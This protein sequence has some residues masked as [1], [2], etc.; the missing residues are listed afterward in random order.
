MN[1][2]IIKTEDGSPTL[3]ANEFGEHYHSIHGARTES[4][5]IFINAGFN[6]CLKPRLSVLEFGFGSGLNALLT[7]F[8]ARRSDR[9]LR[10][11]AIEKYPLLEEETDALSDFFY[12]KHEV[13]IFRK[14]HQAPWNKN[15]EIENGFTLF[16]EKADFLQSNPHGFF[17]VIYFDAFSPDVQPELWKLEM[18]KKI[19]LLCSKG[20]IL[21][22][23]SS[24]GEVRRNLKNVGFSV[25]KLPGPPGKREF[26]RAINNFS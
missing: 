16:K 7:Y 19:Q 25:E 4:E 23:Y 6:A 24:K 13:D 15:T 8:A 17:D 20:A 2:E 10:Y 5:H 14:M 11:H 21:T 12:D 18:F 3:R 9:E 26:L 22:T 1:R